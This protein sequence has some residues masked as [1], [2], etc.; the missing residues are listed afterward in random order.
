[1]TQTA[2][3]IVADD[4][5]PWG[6]ETCFI[7]AP[8]GSSL[9]PRGTA[10]RMRYEEG[11]Q[12]WEK[13][14]EPACETL[15]LK[16]IRADRI[17]DPGEIPE[18]IFQYLRD[19]PVVIADVTEGN[20]NVM[21]ELGLRHTRDLV[22]I[23][24][25]EYARLPFDITS[26][27]TLRFRRTEGGLVEIRDALV[28]SLRAGL[29]GRGKPVTATRVWN[30]LAGVD[31]A[32]ISAAV[33]ASYQPEE[34]DEPDEPGFMDVLADGEAAVVEMT[35]VFERAG[36]SMEE[37]GNLALAAKVKIDESD[38]HNAG[39]AGRL[40]VAM[41]LAKELEPSARSLEEEAAEFNEGVAKMDA[42]VKY[43]IARANEDPVEASESRE[44]FQGTLGMIDAAEQSE[45]GIR[46]MLSGSINLRKI[47][48]VLSP[49]SKTMERAMNQ[50]L[51]GMAVMLEWRTPL[52]EAFGEPE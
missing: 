29:E 12:M 49:V 11:L 48:K 15:G 16:A 35:G 19:S 18:Q 22:T 50:F 20:P 5:E 37:W 39:F 10:G 8:I 52:L 31:A 34:A 21:Y 41:D 13:V 51:R 7:V 47:A 33:V 24:I 26:I 45:S 1:M 23:Q 27:R 2:G 42:M 3:G 9:D 36:A 14:F 32:S 25:G 28:A 46:G 4:T 17:A 43:I 38:A 40:R 30:E 44:F 6:G